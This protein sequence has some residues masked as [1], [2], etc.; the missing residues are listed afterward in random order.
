MFLRNA[1]SVIN[2]KVQMEEMNWPSIKKAVNSGF[3]TVLI[4]VGSI[5]QHGPHLPMFTDSLLAYDLCERLAKKLG[6]TLVAPV[7]RPGCSEH[8]L[9]FP[10]TISVSPSTLRALVDA[11]VGSLVK[12][13]FK[14]FVLIPTHGGNF[15][16]LRKGFRALKKKYPKAKVYGYF[17]L[18]R[19]VVA[20]NEVA[21][22]YRVSAE[23]A[24]AHSGFAE[25]SCV[26][27]VRNEL[28][29]MSSAAPGY[30]GP[31]NK[32]ISQQIIKRGMTAFTKNGVLGDPRESS[33]EAGEKIIQNL[34][35][36]IGAALSEMNLKT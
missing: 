24:G 28:V 11:Y 29:D 1:P 6:R 9:A 13:G 16:P 15:E 36:H 22:R 21:A 14:N 31:F 26:L 10:G 30:V 35:D 17:D 5:E 34:V 23:A 25:T 20:M 7:I 19:F 18:Q 3:R 32:E 2:M 27:A 4:P 12:A 8:H 33:R